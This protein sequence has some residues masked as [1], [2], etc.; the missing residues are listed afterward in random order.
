MDMA[1]ESHPTLLEKALGI[2]LEAHQ[3]QTD[4]QGAVYI[5]HPLRLLAKFRDSTL[6]LIAILRDVIEDSPSRCRTSWM[7]IFPKPSSMQWMR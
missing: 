7:R 2:A 6:Q 4:R 5:L 1:G 3:G